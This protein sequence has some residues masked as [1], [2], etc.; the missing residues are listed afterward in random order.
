M[1]KTISLLIDHNRDHR[2]LHA[3]QAALKTKQLSAGIENIDEL[4][5]QF[6]IGDNEGE[7]ENALMLAREHINNGSYAIITG[8]NDAILYITDIS[9]EI[10]MNE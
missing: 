7:S 10:W 2:T 5:I 6:V 9:I 1:Y 3:I 8:K 4:E